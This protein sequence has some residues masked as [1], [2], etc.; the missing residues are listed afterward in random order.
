MVAELVGVT[1]GVRGAA[2]RNNNVWNTDAIITN[3]A[4]TTQNIEAE[5]NTFTIVAFTD[6]TVDSIT[7]INWGNTGISNAVL[8]CWA[9]I[10]CEAISRN[11]DTDAV[12]ASLTRNASYSSAR[13]N[14]SAL[15]SNAS[16][17]IRALLGNS[18]AGLSIVIFDVGSVNSAG[19]TF[20]G[21][22]N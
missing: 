5:I 16:K 18:A 9:L 22:V 4:S 6:E 20:S 2:R 17:V 10:V 7:R 12:V 13:I 3:L 21:V 14:H 1:V 19:L 11:R 8:S 15:T